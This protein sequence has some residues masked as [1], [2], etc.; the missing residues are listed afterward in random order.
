MSASPSISTELRGIRIG[1][2]V[3]NSEVGLSLDNFLN[4]S[5][6]TGRLATPS[7]LAVRRLTTNWNFCWLHHGHI[8]RLS[9][10]K[11]RLFA[12]ARKEAYASS[13]IFGSF[14]G[15]PSDDDN[16]CG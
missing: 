14:I 10:F 15:T 7:A 5:E 3:P 12:L 8:G 6:D 1:S 11:R 2:F 16:G 4:S 13:E 9:S